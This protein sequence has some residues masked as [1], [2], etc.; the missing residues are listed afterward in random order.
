M[1]SL[2][3]K[4][5]T[6]LGDEYKLLKG[7]RKE[8]RTLMDEL[9]S[10]N[11]LLQ[12][13]SEVNELDV[14]KKEWRNKVRELAYD[15]EDCIDIFMHQ[16]HPGSGNAGLVRKITRKIKKLRA[17]HK[18]AIQI[19]E[20]KSRVVE[21]SGRHDRYK[22]DV[23]SSSDRLMEIDPRLPAMYSE[24]TR[25]VGIESF[26]GVGKT[27]LAKQ[28]YYQIRDRF[29]CTAF[30][31]VSQSPDVLRILSD[32][33]SQIGFGRMRKSN[34]LQKLIENIRGCLSHKSHQLKLPN[35]IRELK[36]LETMDIRDANVHTIPSDIAYLKSLQHLNVPVDA[37][38]P[39]GIGK[40]VTLRALGF[41]N[42]AENSVDNIRDLGELTNLRELDLIWTKQ[43]VKADGPFP[44]WISQL[45]KLTSL[46]IKVDEFPGHAVRLLG[47][48]PCLVYLD[49]SA[50]EDP[51]HD[52][53]FYSNAYPSLREFGFAYTFSSVTFE[54]GAM[55]KLQV[56]HLSFFTRRQQQEGVSLSGIEHLLNLEKLTARL[57]N[58]GDIGVSFRNAILRHPRNQSFN[59]LF[60]RCPY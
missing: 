41:F 11:S 26:G 22:L 4:L 16:L 38:L 59:I 21:E 36:N 48:L 28:V 6:L 49:L 13:L 35:Q 18:I 5:A 40:M 60:P 19:Q 17:R 30:V 14:Q 46:K 31:S 45:D 55:A 10:M 9:S 44:D 32:I 12:N 57:Y 39:N 42:V 37:K 24:A 7:I 54:P 20:L 29:E 8:I 15:I 1:N 58:H 3:C 34:D 47:E 23:P 27:T 53:T 56:L 33:H 2:L 50:T 51:K 52:L 43:V 25:L